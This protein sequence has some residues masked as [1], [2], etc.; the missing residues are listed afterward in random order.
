MLFFSIDAQKKKISGMVYFLFEYTCRKSSTSNGANLNSKSLE[1]GLSTLGIPFN[2]G[3]VDSIRKYHALLVAWNEN[4]N[5][6]SV[7]R[8]EDAVYRHYLDSASLVMA[9][10]FLSRWDSGHVKL[11]DIGSG[12]GL[13]GIIL[14]LLFPK[15]SVTLLESS[16]KKCRFLVE[17]CERLHLSDISIVSERAET[18]A[19]IRDFRAGFDV[20]VSRA[21]SKLNVLA[22]YALPFCKIQG[23]MVALKGRKVDEEVVNAK[24]SI[25][26]L[27][28]RIVKV[29]DCSL[30]IPELDGRLVIV[31]KE[32]PTPGIYPRRVGIPSRRPIT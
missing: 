1:D 22:E 24:A 7:T 18:Q 4:I 20:V 6:T 26:E 13:P 11:L 15:L 12:A 31:E 8:W 3:T 5:L 23:S 29:V 28:G 14:K 30:Q 17:V 27:G 16:S 2:S 25:R 32:K 21:V 19:H 10:S 9:A